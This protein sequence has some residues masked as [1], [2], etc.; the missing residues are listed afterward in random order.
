MYSDIVARVISVALP[1][2]DS[3]NLCAG[4]QVVLRSNR[5]DC[6]IMAVRQAKLP[7]K[8]IVVGYAHPAPVILKTVWC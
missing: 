5:P 1:L 6:I 8:V 4:I 2:V 7:L 3:I